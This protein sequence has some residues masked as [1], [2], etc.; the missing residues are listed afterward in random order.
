[1]WKN[2]YHIP[3]TIDGR[4]VYAIGKNAFRNIQSNIFIPKTVG[5]WSEDCFYKDSLIIYENVKPNTHHE[6]G[7][8]IY[9]AYEYHRVGTGNSTA[10]IDVIRPQGYV[11]CVPDTLWDGIKVVSIN[12]QSLQPIKDNKNRIVCG[13]EKV[14]IDP[15]FSYFE[16]FAD[17]QENGSFFYGFDGKT[18]EINVD[19]DASLH[20]NDLVYCNAQTIRMN[21]VGSGEVRKNFHAYGAHRLAQVDVKGDFENIGDE[22]FNHT[23]IENIIIRGSV[24]NIGADAFSFTCAKSLKLEEGVKTIGEKAFYRCNFKEVTI[25]ASVKT[26]GDKALGYSFNSS[27]EAIVKMLGF[28]IYG[29]KGTAA[30]QYA[31]DNGFT[32]VPVEPSSIN[33]LEISLT[34]PQPDEVPDFNAVVPEGKGYAVD[35]ECGV[36]WFNVTD[37][38]EY[39]D[40]NS[41]YVFEPNKEYRVMITLVTTNDDYKFVATNRRAELNGME[42]GFSDYGWNEDKMVYIES[43]FVCAPEGGAAVKDVGVY[44]DDPT[45]GGYP[46]YYAIPNSDLYSVSDS[47]DDDDQYI[48]NGVGW[49]NETD[50]KPMAYTDAFEAGKTYRR[51][52][53]LATGDF[54]FAQSDEINATF[55]GKPAEIQRITDRSAM[56][57]HYVT[58]PGGTPKIKIGDV[59]GDGEVTI[60]DATYIQRHLASIPIPFVLNEVIADTDE[61][62]LVSIM[63][64]TYI[65]RW[66][67]HMKSNDHIGKPI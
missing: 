39:I 35:N 66:L 6:E 16:P 40:P 58:M 21:V 14:V 36:M 48:S 59:D 64:A 51:T 8:R 20:P 17:I 62:G 37:D 12:S 60:I 3:S 63:D 43:Y 4:Q 25:P 29:V 33:D 32:F 15:V 53:W 18:L 5:E 49:Y 67:A 2:L 44:S 52:V 50:G 26:I 1:M 24:Q 22:A 13:F 28:V 34:E 31:N 7:S 61:D 23:S 38:D 47:A 9:P 45:V 56:L 41:D 55:N 10:T 27:D 54:P 30:E 11:T 19:G 65:Q 57:W 46:F 42:L